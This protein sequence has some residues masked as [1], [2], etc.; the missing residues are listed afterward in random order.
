MK[1]YFFYIVFWNSLNIKKAIVNCYNKI[2][3]VKDSLFFWY[4]SNAHP[5]AGW[6]TCNC[7]NEY[8]RCIYGCFLALSLPY[9][10]QP[11][12]SHSSALYMKIRFSSVQAPNSLFLFPF[13][14]NLQ[15]IF[16][17]K[18]LAFDFNFFFWAG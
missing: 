11:M 17:F 9:K 4:W 16:L 7:Q 14:A 8:E 5:L 6:S 13:E 18:I 12:W 15:H 2:I 1:F 10:S 3:L